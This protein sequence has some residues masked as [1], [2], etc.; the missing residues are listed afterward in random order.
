MGNKPDK[1]PLK[2]FK[3][4][5]TYIVPNTSPITQL[6]IYTESIVRQVHQS[7]HGFIHHFYI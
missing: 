3:N 2:P 1:K 6:N 7:L 4:D 5:D